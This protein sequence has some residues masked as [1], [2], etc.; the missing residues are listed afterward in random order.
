MTPSLLLQIGKPTLWDLDTDYYLHVA[1][2]SKSTA[3]VKSRELGT[4][5]DISMDRMEQCVPRFY[6]LDG[7]CEREASR[8]DRLTLF[9]KILGSTC[10]AC[11]NVSIDRGAMSTIQSDVRTPASSSSSFWMSTVAHRQD[12]ATLQRNL[13]SSIEHDSTIDDV[14]TD[15]NEASTVDSDE[16]S[17]SGLQSPLN[18]VLDV[19][20]FTKKR[21]SLRNVASRGSNNIQNRSSKEA[22]ASLALQSSWKASDLLEV[23][24]T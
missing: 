13:E 14:S 5:Q 10:N 22:M 4:E 2:G 24:Q 20:W 8:T 16:R 17:V 19:D 7:L 3:E 9:D 21:P 11:A 12:A 23:R 1:K 18:D 6:V 15:G